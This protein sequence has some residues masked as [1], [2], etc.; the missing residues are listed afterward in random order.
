[1][2]DSIIKIRLFGE[3][4]RLY[5][6]EIES[7]YKRRFEEA[8]NKIDQSLE[9]A[10]LDIRFFSSL[11]LKE[12]SSIEDL[13][14]HEH[15]STITGLINNLKGK[16]EIKRG[17]KRLLSIEVETL[18]NIGTLFPLYNTINRKPTL[19]SE[20]EMLLIE[21]EIGL[22]AEYHLQTSHFKIGELQF[23]VGDVEVLK[24]RCQILH[25]LKYRDTELQSIRSDTM[26]TYQ[27]CIKTRR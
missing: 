11:K 13:K 3:S 23:F 25:Q 7:N 2:Q 10:I 14:C 21:R 20:A 5:R 22:I 6:L 17:R 27:H 4:I 1:M 9:K 24:E 16:I 12:Y 15:G 8:S 18:N 26:L 19:K